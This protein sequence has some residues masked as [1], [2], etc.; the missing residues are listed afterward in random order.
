MGKMRVI[1]LLLLFLAVVVADGRL[2]REDPSSAAVDR[3]VAAVE[4]C[5]PTY[6]FLP[7]SSNA[8][9]LLFLVAVYEILLTFGGRYVG[10]G[11]DLFFQTIGPSI[12]GASLFQLLGTFPQIIMVLGQFPLLLL[13]KLL[14]NFPFF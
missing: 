11:S 4:T 3:R 5:E 8:W 2:I 10:V 9:G 6:G 12:F 7:C 14:C 1:P 13:I